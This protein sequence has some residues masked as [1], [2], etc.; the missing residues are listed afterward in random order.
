MARAPAS[1]L[2]K[3]RAGL[4]YRPGDPEL[5]AMRKRAQRLTRDYNQTLYGD[6][7]ERAGLL[8]ALFGQPTDAVIRPPFHVDYGSEIVFGRGVFLNYGC[9]ILD[10]ARVEIGDR[11]QIGPYVQIL[12]ADHPR[13]A[14]ERATGAEWGRPIRIGADAWIGGGAILLPGVSIGEGAIVAA[15]AVVTRDVPAGTTVAGNPARP[16]SDGR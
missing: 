14:A 4:P 15:G 1:E 9:V 7:E 6:D 5:V 12:T 8:H 3:M 2:E 16:L 11:V 10:V 13:N